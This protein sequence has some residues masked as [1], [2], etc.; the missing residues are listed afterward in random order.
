LLKETGIGCAVLVVDEEF[1]DVFTARREFLA[2]DDHPKKEF[3]VPE[4][5][6]GSLE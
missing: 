5:R 6:G 1:E 4:V 2:V 3:R